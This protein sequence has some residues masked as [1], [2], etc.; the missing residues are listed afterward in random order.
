MLS[1]CLLVAHQT[2]V[3]A[4]CSV[5]LSMDT[6]F[7]AAMAWRFSSSDIDRINSVRIAPGWTE[8]ARTRCAS[9][10][11][12]R[13]S[14]KSALAVLD[15][16]Y[17]IH[18]S[19]GRGRHD[20]RVVHEHVEGTA[21]P[22]ESRGERVDRSRIE[23]VECLDL[24]PREAC[25]RRPGLVERPGPGDHRRAGAREG[26][27]RLESDPGVSAGHDG[28]G[29]AEVA[30]PDDFARGG[31]LAKTGVDGGLLRRHGAEV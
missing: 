14:A 4:P 31:R 1:S 20:P 8:N 6:A 23:Q 17:A 25:E 13:A 22:E 11:A 9:P 15:C 24:D 5:V 29:S 3:A 19:Y 16:P 27:G 10:R 2:L 18:L 30:L 7:E 26:P 12:S 28:D 21:G